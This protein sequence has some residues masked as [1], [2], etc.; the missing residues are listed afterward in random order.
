[1]FIVNQRVFYSSPHTL[2]LAH[3]R[4]WYLYVYM[5]VV[6]SNPQTNYSFLVDPIAKRLFTLRALLTNDVRSM[7]DS[8]LQTSTNI[9]FI[10]ALITLSFQLVCFQLHTCVALRLAAAIRLAWL[11]LALHVH[12][13]MYRIPSIH[14]VHVY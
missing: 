7:Y 14:L 11:R 4:T 13:M 3:L 10:P 8:I 5:V 12:D 6:A 9:N 1:V 2:W